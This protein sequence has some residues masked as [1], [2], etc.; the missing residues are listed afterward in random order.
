MSDEGQ[1]QPVKP[2]R[3]CG[4]VDR[5][6]PGKGHSL[7]SCRQCERLRNHRKRKEKRMAIMFCTACHTQ[8]QGNCNCGAP[9]LSARERAIEAKSANPGLSDRAIAE[10]AGVSN[11]TVAAIPTN[12]TPGEHSPPVT[13]IGKDGKAYPPKR[14]KPEPKAGFGRVLA[15]R[16]EVQEEFAR[17]QDLW[18][19][20]SPATRALA[21]DYIAQVNLSTKRRKAA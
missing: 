13:K 11:K 7:G 4:S 12:E 6:K 14:E 18:H 5:I 17:F 19:S 21:S 3:K 2:C 10:I 16:P 9:Y 8:G 15:V 1:I 20:L